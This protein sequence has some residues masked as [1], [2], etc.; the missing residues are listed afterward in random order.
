MQQRQ[1]PNMRIII[2]SAGRRVYLVQ[3][4]QEAVRQANIGGQVIVL[5][6]DPH[7]AAAAL[8][9]E[10][11]HIPAFTSPDYAPSLFELVDELS[12]D[13]FISLNDYELTELAE[14]LAEDLR[15]RG[16]VVPV[17]DTESHRA[18]ADKF[19]MAQTLHQAG[20]STPTTVLLSNQPA[21]QEL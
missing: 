19:L 4:F 17:L 8:A 15:L 2:S 7:A 11:R 20:I 3:W 6:H 13:L 16:I 9:D 12:P 18:V 21:V 14:G 5:D 1:E 10:Y